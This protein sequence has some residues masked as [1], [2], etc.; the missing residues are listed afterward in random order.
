MLCLWLILFFFALVIAGPT[1]HSIDDTS[2]LFSDFAHTD[3]ARRECI[4]C[5]DEVLMYGLDPNRLFDRSVTRF[6]QIS[7]PANNGPAE[8]LSGVVLNFTGT[9][10]YLFLG[11]PPINTLYLGVPQAPYPAE[12]VGFVSLDGNPVNLGVFDRFHPRNKTFTVR[13]TAEAQYPCVW[14]TTGIPDGPHTVTLDTGGSPLMLD[15]AVYTSNDPDSASSASSSSQSSTVSS[16]S[17]T[18]P[19]S[20]KRH[21]AGAIAGMKS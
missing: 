10:F 14:F 9:A 3:E 4:G 21:P 1:N 5:I 19:P 18:P 12:L 15:Y 2:P 11:V 7:S 13:T 8:G 17:A 16:H 20:H 6:P